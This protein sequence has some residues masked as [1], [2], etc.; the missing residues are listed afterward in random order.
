MH[1]IDI[2]SIQIPDLDRFCPKYLKCNKQKIRAPIEKQG[3]C[4]SC[5]SVS[6]VLNI[7]YGERTVIPLFILELLIGFNTGVDIGC[8]DGGVPDNGYEYIFRKRV[9]IDDDYPY[10]QGESIEIIPCSEV[11]LGGMGIYLQTGCVRSLCVDPYR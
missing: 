10:E 1:E 2:P 4:T 7:H 3:P 11:R 9:S 5:F 8:T 6:V